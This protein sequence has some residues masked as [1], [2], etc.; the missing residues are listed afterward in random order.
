MYDL[1]DAIKRL[2]E[3]I[4][5]TISG[6]TVA[7]DI[8]N[9]IAKYRSLTGKLVLSPIL[10]RDALKAYN[11]IKACGIS[12]EQLVEILRNYAQYEVALQE[13]KS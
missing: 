4:N 6:K 8:E 13:G 1:L 10:V 7:D 11:L 2:G 12:D 3:G 9:E 5:S